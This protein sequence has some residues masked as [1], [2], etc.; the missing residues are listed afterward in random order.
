MARPALIWVTYDDSPII[1]SVPAPPPVE[2]LLSMPVHCWLIP[3]LFKRSRVRDM[4]HAM[5]QAP[6]A[7]R[8]LT[9]QRAGVGVAGDVQG[10]VRDEDPRRD[11]ERLIG[12]ESPR[13]AESFRRRSVCFN[14]DSPFKIY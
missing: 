10:L 13:A 7:E 1:R 8:T 5:T 3:D 14:R 2:L 6:R 9:A 4:A 12:D 11:E